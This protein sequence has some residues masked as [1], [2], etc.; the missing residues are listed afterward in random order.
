MH[1]RTTQAGGFFLIVAMFAGIAW[2]LNSG[3]PM[4]GLLAGTGIGIA[5]AL[6]VWLVDRRRR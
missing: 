3:Q 4:L 1:S 2:G 5:I 6:A